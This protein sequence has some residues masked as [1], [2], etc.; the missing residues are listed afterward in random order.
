MKPSKNFHIII[1]FIILAFVNQAFAAGIPTL[2]LRDA[3][4][5][6]LRYNPSIRSGE[7]NRMIDKFNLRLQQNAFEVQYALSGTAF[8]ARTK[9]TTPTI[10]NGRI[11]TITHS[12]TFGLTP[13]VSW[14]NVYG[15][16][17][18]FDLQN[19]ASTGYFPQLTLEYKQPLLR[20]HRRS[21][22]EAPL[23]NAIDQEKI[24]RLS[25]KN[26]IMYTV[27]PNSS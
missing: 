27:L 24:G 13:D 22:V 20:G 10:N 12:N 3:I 19:N 14:K 26:T 9:T 4:F 21:I 2:T 15:G 23:L 18:S 16:Q 11:A 25:L 1:F 7:F 6:S 8:T 5:L 17:A